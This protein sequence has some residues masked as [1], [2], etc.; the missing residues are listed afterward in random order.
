MAF[1]DVALVVGGAVGLEGTAAVIGG[2]A[3]IG[4][5][6]G[7]AYSAITGDGNILNS[8]LTGG[9]IGGAGAYGLGSLGAGGTGVQGAM[10]GPFWGTPAATAVTTPTA[11]SL[12]A[13][14]A[15][16]VE[17]AIN[18]ATGLPYS[19]VSGLTQAGSSVASQEAASA[20]AKEAA[21]T[22]A[23]ESGKKILGYGLAGTAAMQ[24]LGNRNP[25]GAN[26]PAS[27]TDPGSIRPYEFHPNQN[28]GTGQYPSPYA[29]ASYDAAGNPVL[30]TRERN[31]FDQQYTAMTPYS[32]RVGTANPNKP[33]GA[34]T[35]G[36]MA[37]G[38]PVERMTQNV[39]G[40][41]GNMF[42]QSQQEHTY[43]STPTQMPASAEVIRSDYDAK[44]NPYTGVM[45]ANGGIAKFADKGMVDEEAELRKIVMNN[46][47]KLNPDQLQDVFA[48]EDMR[49]KQFLM[50]NMPNYAAAMRPSVSGMIEGAQYGDRMQQA[51][52]DIAKNQALKMGQ[53]FTPQTDYARFQP[54]IQDIDNYGGIASIGKQIAPD[55]R[56]N[57]MAD[58]QRT[59]Y[60][61]NALE[62]VRRVGAGIDRKIGKDANLSAYYEQDPMGRNKAGGVRYTQQFADGGLPSLGYKGYGA[63]NEQPTVNRSN[64]IGDYLL[65]QIISQPEK[66]SSGVVV[67]GAANTES[68]SGAASNPEDNPILRAMYQKQ[69]ENPQYEFTQPELVS[70]WQAYNPNSFAYN[71]QASKYSAA[72]PNDMQLN[73]FKQQMADYMAQDAQRRAQE[74]Q[75]VYAVDGGGGKAG[76][77]MP[78]DLGGYSDGGRLLKGPGDGVSDDIP[79]TIAGKQ[80]ARLA[81][82]EFVIPARI[83][84][85]IGNGSTDAGAKRL[86]AMMDRIQ[87]GRKKTIGKKNIAKDTKAK[88]HLLA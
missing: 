19:E 36:L 9:L 58:L 67:G 4:A 51:Y 31:Y 37:V 49:E 56:M 72:T 65:N 64:P 87:E 42:P 38:G 78:Y 84:S 30:D 10:A 14:N 41:Q 60:D 70:G 68:S 53:D 8:M 85:E 54:R 43:F 86:Y 23:L 17:G 73:T 3:L 62:S 39:M 2:G 45:M 22:A 82:G 25:K 20:A 88:R 81:D 74:Q 80:P 48:T 21:K 28:A 32:A 63:T 47:K 5:G 79:A 46:L 44:T 71:Q 33:I 18:P 27:A 12:T 34:A 50:K 1:V 69:L 26:A 16:L 40:G 83:V 76:G 77:L 57:L 59:P 52:G 24:L 75:P 6:V 11:T 35:G 66:Q 13:G 55:T 29:T 15:A 61:K 7:G